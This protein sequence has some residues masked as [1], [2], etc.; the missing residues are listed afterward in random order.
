MKCT[1]RRV[2]KVTVT[3]NWDL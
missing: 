3:E 1:P 2:T